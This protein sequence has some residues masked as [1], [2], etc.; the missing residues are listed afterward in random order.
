[1]PLVLK[2]KAQTKRVITI[3]TGVADLDLTNDVEVDI[4]S[5]YG[6]SKA[7]MNLI[8][9]KFSVQYKKDGVL[10]MGISPGLVETGHY[11]D[12]MCFPIDNFLVGELLLICDDSQSGGDAGYGGI[13]GQVAGVCAAF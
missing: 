12:G 13:R 2:S 9:A 11:V 7:A 4:G 5:L 3:T 1:M 6:A 8:V 10:F